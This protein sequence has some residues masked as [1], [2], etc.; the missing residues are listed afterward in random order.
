MYMIVDNVKGHFAQIYQ[1]IYITDTGDETISNAETAMEYLSTA[2]KSGDSNHKSAEACDGR[3]L[4]LDLLRVHNGI[5]DAEVRD[6]ALYFELPAV[7]TG[8]DCNA[9]VVKNLLD[10]MEDL[11]HEISRKY[12]RD[13]ER[14]SIRITETRTCRC[15][16]LTSIL[17]RFAEFSTALRK[18]QIR[19][20]YLLMPTVQ[21]RLSAE[22]AGTEYVEA[23]SGEFA[24]LVR[25]AVMD[26]RDLCASAERLQLEMFALTGGTGCPELVTT[27]ATRMTEFVRRLKLQFQ[28]ERMV[29]QTQAA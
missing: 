26:H 29:L 25:D 13:L 11:H 6:A 17:E 4:A 18:W 5:L 9:T 27:F 15:E 22:L 24:D 21:Q 19:D 12:I 23:Y 1:R 10:K 8:R 28:L 3:A 7:G 14:L 2:G 20:Q 16:A